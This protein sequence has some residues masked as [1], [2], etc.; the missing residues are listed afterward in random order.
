ML[1]SDRKAD[2]VVKAIGWV[3]ETLNLRYLWNVQ[4]GSSSKQLNLMVCGVGG[5]P[6]LELKIGATSPYIAW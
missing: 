6:G 5:S 3:L 4:G 2:L 1:D